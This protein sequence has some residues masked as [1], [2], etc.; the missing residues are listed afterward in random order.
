MRLADAYD[1]LGIEMAENPTT[2]TR[3]EAQRAYRKMAL[4]H[5]PDRS[6]DADAT[7]KFQTIGEAWER[8][9]QF[10]DNPR[11]YGAHA[12]APDRDE[13]PPQGSARN[14]YQNPASWEDLFSRWFGT[15]GSRGAAGPRWSEADFQPPPQHGSGCKCATCKA[16]RR[17][18][19]IFAQ[20]ARAREARRQ[21]ALRVMA[22]AKQRAKDEAERTREQS[23]EEARVRRAQEEERSRVAA[24]RC[25][26]TAAT[27][28]TLLDSSLD[29]D[30]SLDDLLDQFGEWKAAVDA[31]TKAQLETQ[32]TPAEAELLRRA[33]GRL[34]AIEV[35]AAAAAE[36][37]EA[38]EAQEAQ[39]LAEAE[40]AAEEDSSSTGQPT[41]ALG[42]RG[43]KK[44][45]KE[46]ARAMA[47]R[48]MAALGAAQD[49]PELMAA[50]EEAEALSSHGACRVKGLSEQLESA[51]ERLDGLLDANGEV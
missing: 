2:D 38:Q 31:G 51:R 34:D 16:E 8:V 27:L 33:V 22:D 14:S 20:R 11:R 3:D 41:M 4:R 42:K 13:E 37:R 24:E 43:S 15:D 49:A 35:A 25:T 48:A 30:A 6:P 36:A 17:R 46:A 39:E 29:L 19:E 44:K 32:G 40:E 28:S 9:Q 1:I 5:H 21:E 26:K 50:I 45:Q 47:V 23:M 7:H 18:E 10:H 12:D